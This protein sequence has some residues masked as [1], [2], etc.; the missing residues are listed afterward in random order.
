MRSIRRI[1][2]A[3]ARPIAPHSIRVRG[4]TQF[5]A[6]HVR[7]SCL[8]RYSHQTEPIAKPLS[9]L[10]MGRRKRKKTNEQRPKPTPGAKI[11]AKYA[12][13][14]RRSSD[15]VIVYPNKMAKEIAIP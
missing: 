7:F 10:N 15:V 5:I 3:L 2:P 1:R 6:G 8:W 9:T 11:H 13:K 12:G 14:D 4:R